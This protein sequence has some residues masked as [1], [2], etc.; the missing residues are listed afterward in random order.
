MTCRNVRIRLLVENTR[1]SYRIVHIHTYI[2]RAGERAFVNQALFQPRTQ[3]PTLRSRCLLLRGISKDINKR[4]QSSF[5]APFD[6]L[7]ARAC[8]AVRRVIMRL[9]LQLHAVHRTAEREISSWSAETQ[10]V[11]QASFL[12]PFS[13]KKTDVTRAYT[14]FFNLD[15][16]KNNPYFRS[17]PI[18]LFPNYGHFQGSYCWQ[19]QATLLEK[20]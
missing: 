15:Y 5:P 17:P 2:H 14:F 10:R 19:L 16:S 20:L 6:S 11:I 18:V 7:N 13:Q 9:S 1:C 4:P 3:R 8:I 12:F